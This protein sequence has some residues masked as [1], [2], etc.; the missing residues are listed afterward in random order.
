MAEKQDNVLVSVSASA[1]ASPL[2]RWNTAMRMEQE[3]QQ[4]KAAHPHHTAAASL[5]WEFTKKHTH[6]HTHKRR[7]RRNSLNGRI[8]A[9]VSSCGNITNVSHAQPVTCNSRC[10]LVAKQCSNVKVNVKKK[11]KKSNNFQPKER[12]NHFQCN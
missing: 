3:P 2:Q 11:I 9:A 7:H 10:Q 12:I 4:H 5:A 1:S 6:T 8:K